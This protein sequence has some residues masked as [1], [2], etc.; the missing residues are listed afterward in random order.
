[1]PRAFW[2]LMIAI[3]VN[4]L[5]SVVGLFLTMW[6]CEVH[7]LSEIDA[8]VIVG[9]LG[10]GA[11]L[12][13]PIGGWMADHF[14][15]RTTMVTSL[16]LSGLVMVV[17]PSLP[18]NQ[19][20]LACALGILTFFSE[21]HR[22]AGSA[23]I[24]DLVAPPRRPRAYGIF[25]VIINLAFGIGALVGG[26]VVRH[27]FSALFYIDA[28]TSL[29]A[30]VLL[31]RFCPESRPTPSRDAAT[32]T[33]PLAISTWIFMVFLFFYLLVSI[34]ATQMNTNLPLYIRDFGASRDEQMQ[35]YGSLVA[36]N[37]FG[38]VIAQLPISRLLDR[39]SASAAL[40]LGALLYGAGYGLV[41]FPYAPW[42]LVV[43]MAVITAGEMVFMPAGSAYVAD[44]AP[45]ERRGR[46]MG[47][48][49]MMYGIARTIGPAL[50]SLVIARH[51]DRAVWLL[52]PA[53]GI[54]A[55][56]G[57]AIVCR[58]PRPHAPA[59]RQN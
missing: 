50:A 33:A 19:F 34:I 15:R 17:L 12:G 31:I 6:L 40:A 51:G 53:L 36:I 27:S 43:A 39:L 18:P 23:A 2:I 56:L 47:W 13:S 7:K 30:V 41:A 57:L 55:A 14:G 10:I 16:L 45:V 3:F 46:Y 38:V 28:I 59:L 49:I 26:W 22:P 37:G 29:L 35:F 11:M 1:M 4:R 5:G 52:S 8:T 32:S 42:L 44:I 21:M 25:R 24:A 54:F 9:S 58:G 48:L 20:V